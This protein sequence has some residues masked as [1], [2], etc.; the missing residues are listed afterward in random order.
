M[1][2]AL[3]WLCAA[4]GEPIFL[5]PTNTNHDSYMELDAEQT[6]IVLAHHLRLDALAEPHSN[7][8]LGGNDRVFETYLAQVAHNGED[9]VGRGME[10]AMI[11]DVESS[12]TGELNS[13]NS[14]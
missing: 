8:V 7:I 10:S 1:L 14:Q 13:V 3:C 11:V 12:S 9:F 6:S 4:N 5:Y 2:F